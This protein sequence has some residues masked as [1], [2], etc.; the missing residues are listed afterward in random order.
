MEEPR[1]EPLTAKEMSTLTYNLINWTDKEDLAKLVVKAMELARCSAISV[2]PEIE[3][4]PGH[5]EKIA[6]LMAVT[7]V[8]MKEVA[9]LTEKGHRK[10]KLLGKEQKN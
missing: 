4:P 2:H 8:W 10:A 9:E 7:E 1:M 6:R 3:Y 5:W